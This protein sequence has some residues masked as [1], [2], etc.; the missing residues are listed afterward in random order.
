V[1][2]GGQYQVAIFDAIGECAAVL[3]ATLRRKL[4]ELDLDPAELSFFD[5]SSAG[6]VD[7]QLPRV[8]V[9]FSDDAR[10]K[11]FAAAVALLMENAAVVVPVVRSVENFNAQV[12]E[13]LYPVNALKLNP[14]DRE[15]EDVASLVLELFGLLRN[16]R[17]LFISYK[18]TESTDVALQLHDRLDARS[19]D[20]FLDTMSVRP[21]DVFQET[22]WHRMADSDLVV[23]LYT[24]S[25]LESGWVAQELSRA[26]GMG[27][28]VL[29]VVWP[30]VARDRRTE[31]LEP[32]YLEPGD[33]EDARLVRLNG[34]KLDEL[35]VEVERLR[36][37]SLAAREALLVGNLCDL[38]R[39][40]S[41]EP[42]VQRTRY[43]DLHCAGDGPPTRVIPALGVP[44]AQAI[45]R[46]T[47]LA[48]ADDEP[49]SIVLLYE[50]ISVATEWLGHLAWLDEYLP[51]KTV[52]TA[53]L[54]AWLPNLCR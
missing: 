48:A 20:V 50:S 4:G 21:A 39:R 15:L 40:H 1:S 11:G 28:T 37:R 34:A 42:V 22:L 14:Q 2:A 51:V 36:A 33:F 27:I 47:T 24:Q 41:I 3:R 31:L 54:A 9:L 5:E 45:Q 10:G 8:G 29:Q 12:P 46:C 26:S 7:P 16:R 19:F 32:V 35:A 43:V 38:A 13:A 23:L 44:D 6:E 17:R 25:V 18:R 30:G 52:K 49:R 53:D